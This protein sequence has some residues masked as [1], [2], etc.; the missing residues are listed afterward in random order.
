M[1][2][3]IKDALLALSDVFDDEAIVNLELAEEA[4]YGLIQNWNLDQYRE[5]LD[6]DVAKA[7]L[8]RQA[9]TSLRVQDTEILT[10]T[11]LP[12]FPP[13]LTRGLAGVPQGYDPRDP[14]QYWEDPNTGELWRWDGKRKT[15]PEDRW[16][17]GEP[18][19]VAV[20][21]HRTV[22]GVPVPDEQEAHD[23][24]AQ[25][26]DW[27]HR[28]LDTWIGHGGKPYGYVSREK[29]D[30]FLLAQARARNDQNNSLILRSP[31]VA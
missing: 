13:Y 2:K 29:R 25:E 23:A 5:V 12:D 21:R 18:H 3:A 7:V 9:V 16:P 10:S 20:V 22:G 15:S 19:R 14:T 1:D 30:A 8:A 31:K 17:H 24:N 26:L 27:F 6:G 11:A 28:G 4:G